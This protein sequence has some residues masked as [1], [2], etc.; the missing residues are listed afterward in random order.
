MLPGAPPTGAPW[1]GPHQGEEPSRCHRAGR[2]ALTRTTGHD[3]DRRRTLPVDSTP[4]RARGEERQE[5]VLQQRTVGTISVTSPRRSRSRHRP[6]RHADPAGAD[7]AAD[8]R[9]DQGHLARRRVQRRTR[10]DQA[11]HRLDH[12]TADSSCASRRPVLAVSRTKGDH[13]ARVGEQTR[14]R[15]RPRPGRA[16]AQ[17]VARD[18]VGYA[19]VLPFF[20]VFLAFSVYPWLDTAW[21]SLHDTRLSTY[22]QSSH[23]AGELR[24][25]FTNQFF[26][27]A[28]RT[29]SRSGSPRR[30][31]S[32]AWL[33]ASPTC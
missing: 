2:M 14:V 8:Q 20:V 15:R 5:R 16:P 24:N 25:L 33:S 19:Y 9:R 30:S 26:W 1:L 6:L 12:R 28:Y 4:H 18:R 29:P 10:P 21:V 32:S 27:N 17:Q 7:H 22:D 31:P 13:D 23:R 11:D 3:V